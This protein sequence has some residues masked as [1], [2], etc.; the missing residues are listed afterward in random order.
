M[1]EFLGGA[2][3]GSV[4]GTMYHG[5]L[6]SDE[7]RRAFLADVAAA[8]GRDLVP[9][10][11]SFA[12]A[13]AKRL[14]HLGDLAEKHLDVDALLALTRDGAPDVPVLAPGGTA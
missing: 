11:A 14:D 9:S 5:S 7:F 3:D 2:H 12:A 10:N 4:Y 13:R 6:E 1:D 8:A